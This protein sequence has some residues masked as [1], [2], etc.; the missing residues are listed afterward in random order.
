VVHG[1][2]R[3]QAQLF[4]IAAEHIRVDEG[5]GDML[6]SV[7]GFVFSLVFCA[8]LFVLPAVAKNRA[9]AVVSACFAAFSAIASTA[10]LLAVKGIISDTLALVAVPPLTA[11]C[12]LS[13]IMSDYSVF[14]S[15]LIAFTLIAALNLILT[16]RKSAVAKA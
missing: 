6:P 7:L 9:F 2:R 14:Y 11:F 1:G 12:G 4:A 5:P 10:G 15:V 8:C 3:E 16:A 13:Y